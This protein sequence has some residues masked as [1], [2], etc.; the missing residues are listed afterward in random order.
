[1]KKGLLKG[2]RGPLSLAFEGKLGKTLAPVL[3]FAPFQIPRL[4]GC[5]LVPDISAT[6]TTATVP[7]YSNFACTSVTFKSSTALLNG[8]L[9]TNK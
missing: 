3:W 1:M 7:C 2:C 5:L 8:P 9:H 4:I 6:D